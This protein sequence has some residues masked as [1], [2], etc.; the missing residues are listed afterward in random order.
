MKIETKKLQSLLN[1]ASK[2]VGNNKL[3]P[4][5][6]LICIEAKDNNITLTTTD[7][8]NYL[9]ISDS[10]VD[11]DIYVVTDFDAL[12]KLV[13]KFT[14]DFT[15]L[16]INKNSL[17]VVANGKYNLPLM[18]TEDGNSIR[19][20]NPT[21]KF[22]KDGSE[23]LKTEVVNKVI[24]NIKSAAS[25]NLSV[26]YLNSCYI[27]DVAVASDS[28]VASMLNENILTKPQLF[29]LKVL[30]L[31]ELV[32][33]D[34]IKLNYND[35]ALL[36]S[37]GSVVVY[38]NI[39]SNVDEFPIDVIKSL[40]E[41]KVEN[42][43]KLKTLELKG[44]LDRASLFTDSLLDL[45]FSEKNVKI[46]TEDSSM[47]E[48]LAYEEI[49]KA[50]KFN[51]KIDISLLKQQLSSIKSDTLVLYYGNDKIIKIVDEDIVKIIA[52]GE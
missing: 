18:L 2:C 43:V 15:E 33:E 34:T 14:T 41:Q 48:K 1:K 5:T 27:G 31:L 51:C 32:E 37:S 45:S 42:E 44:L 28:L 24:K 46:S 35:T 49:I 23:T 11:E 36:F 21:D 50:G 6:S 20:P 52:L 29:T 19:F 39:T 4:L 30:S 10:G 16:S 12:Y 25:A 47:E 13:S 38:S 22:K 7:S 40:F 17:K 9:Y 26:P 3:F 8:T